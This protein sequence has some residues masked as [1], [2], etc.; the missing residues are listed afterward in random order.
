M[1]FF[2]KD[3]L[4]IYSFIYLKGGGGDRKTETERQ[5]ET[6]RGRLTE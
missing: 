5:R 4:S 1:Y 3:Y 6:E 2:K